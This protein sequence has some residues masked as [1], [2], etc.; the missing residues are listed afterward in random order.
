[1]KNLQDDTFTLDNFE[2]S[3]YFLW[4][5]IQRNE[6][7]I[8]EIELQKIM[9]QYCQKMKEGTEADAFSVD[10]ASEFI[11]VAASLMLLKSKTLLPKQDQVMQLEEEEPDPRFEVIHHLIDYCRF[12]D[13]AKEL[14]HREDQ[15]NG[16]YLRGVD[17]PPQAKK[18]LGIEHLSLQDLALLFQQLLER[19]APH[20]GIIEE[21]NWRVSDKILAI[22]KDLLI[23]ISIPFEILFNPQKCRGE[24][25]V[26]FLAVLELMKLGEL[27]IIKDVTTGIVIL[28]AETQP[29]GN[30]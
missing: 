26:T 30:S 13:V 10:G 18:T 6:I 19:A 8:Y 11:G 2:G 21:E 15:Q 25:I 29:N 28:T 5:L 4:Q 3:L 14:S 16:F 9:L 27:C 1:M 22:R 23:L 17:G 7:D 20:C 24:L 12:K